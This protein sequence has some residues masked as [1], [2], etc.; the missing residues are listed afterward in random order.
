MAIRTERAQK[1]NAI[2]LSKEPIRIISVQGKRADQTFFTNIQ[3]YSL[4]GKDIIARRVYDEIKVE[5]EDGV[6]TEFQ[7]GLEKD[8]LN[9]QVSFFGGAIQIN[10]VI[11]AGNTAKQ[12]RDA[13]EVS[14]NGSVL[15]LNV[16]GLVSLVENA[17]ERIATSDEPVMSILTD[18]VKNVNLS[19]VSVSKND[20]ATLTGKTTSD[21]FLKLTITTG[22]PSGLN[23]ALKEAGV[24]ESKRRE[25]LQEAST[26]PEVVTVSVN[27]NR[28]KSF[29]S[30]VQKTIRNQNNAIGNP[31]GSIKGFDLGGFGFGQLGMPLANM[32]GNLIG[33]LLNVNIPSIPNVPVPGIAEGVQIPVGEIAPPNVIE[34]TGQT[35]ISKTIQK[36]NLTSPNVKNT[37]PPL[38]VKAQT[39]EFEGALSTSRNSTYV[40]ENVGGPEELKFELRNSTREITT[41]VVHWSRTFSDL[42]WDAKDIG[43]LQTATQLANK[44]EGVSNAQILAA[45]GVDSGLQFHYLIL[46]NGTIQRGRPLDL[47]GPTFTGFGRYAVHVCFVAGFNCPSGTPNKEKFLSDASITAE[48][49]K[50][51]DEV[52]RAF[53]AAK[54]GGGEFVGYN[55]MPYGMLG[56]GFNVPEYMASKYNKTTVYIPDDFNKEE[57]LSPDEIV[58]RK[59][60]SE[61]IKPSQPNTPPKKI[62]TPVDPT[63][64]DPGEIDARNAEWK[65]LK[66][67]ERRLRSE[68]LELIERYKAAQVD[69]NVSVDQVNQIKAQLDAKKQELDEARKAVDEARKKLLNDGYYW[70]RQKDAWINPDLDNIEAL[71]PTQQAA[72]VPGVT[73]DDTRGRFR[74]LNPKT[75]QYQFFDDIKSAER[76]TLQ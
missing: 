20:I 40:F 15:G 50:S 33:K 27:T 61:P 70:D 35:N 36:S 46:R 71:S 67:A 63:E 47:I 11:D 52:V 17:Q 73:Y 74:A 2:A 7:K 32:L 5:Y 43:G 44:P 59:P 19:E 18:T 57:A 60:N 1:T 29:A 41:M 30:T 4:N 72:R 38:N 53:D 8:F 55:Q 54:D 12:Q 66:S 6:K 28:V 64:P 10:N 37:K 56:P 42:D 76:Y 22:S 39:S 48:Q 68:R 69:P 26:L 9:G 24:K 51:F 3:S 31:A 49:W 62:V 23:N 21:G 75:N 16:G 25:A 58:N 45:L 34:A 13:V 65:Q 14:K